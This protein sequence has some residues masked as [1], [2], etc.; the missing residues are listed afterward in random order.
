MTTATKPAKRPAN[1]HFSSG[2]CAKRP[3][4]SLENLDKA[5][6]GRSHRAKEGK[7]RLKLAIDK[8]KALLGLPPGYRVRHR[9]GLR[10]RRLRDGHVDHAG[11]SAASTRWPG[12]A[13]A[14]AG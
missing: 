3:G 7:A 11:R 10:H 9:A 8:T 1:P 5:F 4:W 14:R 2:P 12:R 6:L 13:S